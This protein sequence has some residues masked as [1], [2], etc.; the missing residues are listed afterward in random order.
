M[1]LYLRERIELDIASK[2]LFYFSSHGDGVSYNGVGTL[3]QIVARLMEELEEDQEGVID[4]LC[5]G[6]GDMSIGILRA[7]GH[8]RLKYRLDGEQYG[9]FIYEISEELK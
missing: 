6:S 3:E 4:W 7:N 1:A 5:Q 8:D 9:M 2:K